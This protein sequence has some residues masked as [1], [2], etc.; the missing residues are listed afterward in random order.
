MLNN[1]TPSKMISSSNK[2]ESVNLYGDI[3]IDAKSVEE[4]NDIVSLLK[5][6]KHYKNMR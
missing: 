1:A 6:V 4:F 5:G 2:Q 3:V